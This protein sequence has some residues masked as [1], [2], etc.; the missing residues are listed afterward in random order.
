MR[1]YSK[2]KSELHRFRQWVGAIGVSE[3]DY[4][5]GGNCDLFIARTTLQNLHWLPRG[6]NTDDVLLRNSGH[7]TLIN[8]SVRAGNMPYLSGYSRGVTTRHF[9]KDGWLYIVVARY[10]GVDVLLRN[11]GDG[12]FDRPV[13]V[14]YFA[15]QWD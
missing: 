2:Y 4:Y 14:G 9:D 13:A 5:N 15:K 6:V 11:S 12:T 8:E 3:L 10:T 7:V 1:A